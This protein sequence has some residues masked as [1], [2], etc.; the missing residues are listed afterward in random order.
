MNKTE[1]VLAPRRSVA[2]AAGCIEGVNK[3]RVDEG[4][5]PVLEAAQHADALRRSLNA[6]KEQP[7]RKVLVSAQQPSICPFCGTIPE[8]KLIDTVGYRGRQHVQTSLECCIAMEGMATDGETTFRPPP[9]K[10]VAEAKAAL[11]SQWNARI[12]DEPLPLSEY[13]EDMGP[14]VWWKFPVDEPAWV[15]SPNYD[16]WPGYHTHFTPHPVVP[17]EPA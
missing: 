8:F 3:R 2:Y 7:F 17:G 14:V 1:F 16:T 13:H 4:R 5:A 11:I 15:G 10:W 12:V 9:D 6:P